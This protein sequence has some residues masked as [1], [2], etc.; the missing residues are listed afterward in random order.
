MWLVCL[1][2][3]ETAKLFSRMVKPFPFLLL[4]SESSSFSQ[5]LVESVFSCCNRCVGMANRNVTVGFF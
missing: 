1:I 5:H 3:S 4:A 2:L